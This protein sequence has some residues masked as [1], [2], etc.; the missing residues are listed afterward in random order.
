MAWNP[1]T[2]GECTSGKAWTQ[3]VARKVK[4]CLEYLYGVVGSSGDKLQNGGFELDSDSDGIPDGWTV[5]LYPGGSGEAYTTTP[6]QG[7]K[8]WSFTHP[9]GA[10]NGGG[11][12]QSDYVECTQYKQMNFGVLLWAT[13]AGMKTILE[14]QYYDKG[15]AAIGGATNIA[16]ITSNPATPTRYYYEITPAA[17]AKYLKIKLIAGYTDTDVAGTT[18]FDDVLLNDSLV[19]AR[20]VD[21][22]TTEAKL[23]ASAVSQSKLK[24]SAGEVSVSVPA[25]GTA[26]TSALPG[27][28]YGFQFRGK[29]STGNIYVAGWSTAVLGL[30][31][32]APGVKFGNNGGDEQTGYAEQRYVTSSGEVFWLFI[33]RDKVSKKT[34][35]TYAAPDHPCMGRGGKPI[36]VPHP[37]GS[38]DPAK[39]EIVV[40]NP[41][42]SEL[43][44]LTNK[45]VD[46]D[47]AKADRSLLQVILEEYEVDEK[48]GSPDWPKKAVTVGLPPGVD[49]KRMPEGTVLTPVK[50]VIPDV[51]FVRRTLRVK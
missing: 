2:T 36:V 50:K 23:A 3:A 5:A 32:V 34:I 24:T 9:G 33:L 12:I 42:E 40:V 47:E 44:E 4:D 38:F 41:N 1:L 22:S 11:S 35:A 49:W 16:T 19:T 51:G 29:G 26:N 37:F 46:L 13:A 7:A 25:A 39:H 21:L 14:V 17:G 43:Q 6:A 18:Y 45:T 48:G 28:E 27:G 31:Y 10:G 8:S 20:L 15:K 30:S